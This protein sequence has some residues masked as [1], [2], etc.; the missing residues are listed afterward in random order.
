MHSDLTAPQA[1]YAVHRKKRGQSDSQTNVLLAADEFFAAK[2]L[3]SWCAMP[4]ECICASVFRIPRMIVRTSPWKSTQAMK[5]SG[6]EDPQSWHRIASNLVKY[7]SPASTGYHARRKLASQQPAKSRGLYFTTR[8]AGS[9]SS[10]NCSEA[11]SRGKK[12]NNEK[13][14]ARWRHA[15]QEWFACAFRWAWSG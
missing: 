13:K 10:W 3:I 12:K 2:T 1:A 14:G 8:P 5:S 9:S 4:R 15:P 11:R 6:Y 7:P